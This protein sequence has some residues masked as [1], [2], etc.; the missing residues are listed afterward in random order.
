MF[1]YLIDFFRYKRRRLLSAGMTDQGLVRQ[2]NEDAFQIIN[3][4]RIFI[5]ADGMGG[6]NAGEVASRVAIETLVKYF[7][8]IPAR[9]L[10]NSTE[11]IQHT[12]ITGLRQANDIIITMAN[13]N[14]GMRGMGCTLVACLVGKDVLHS[15]H[16]GDTRCY[17]AQ[18]DKMIQ[19][20]HDHSMFATLNQD[21]TLDPSHEKM[22][23]KRNVVTRAI[24]YIFKEDPEYNCH[25]IKRGDRI[26]LCSDGLWSMLTDEAMHQIITTAANPESAAS[27]LIERANEAGGKDNITA[28]VIFY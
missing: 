17:L 7:A 1:N 11:S 22:P 19:I 15:C 21:A 14:R 25:P 5:V 6:H 10:Y 3:D 18:P 4:R 26:L 16:V 23:A 8:T 13:D 2:Q 20:T 28:V 12:L 9:R 24:G 27:Q